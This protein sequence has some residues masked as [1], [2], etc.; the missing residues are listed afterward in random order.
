MLT[1]KHSGKGGMQWTPVCPVAKFKASYTL[2]HK[3]A[4]GQSNSDTPLALDSPGSL[5][6]PLAI[7]SPQAKPNQTR[8]FHSP[9]LSSLYQF[10]PITQKKEP[11]ASASADSLTKGY[12]T[13]A[14]STK[15]LCH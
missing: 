10:L 3:D 9:A 15:V 8:T 14:S 11:P 2:L 12:S 4:V 1:H 7:P 13:W 6:L 5:D